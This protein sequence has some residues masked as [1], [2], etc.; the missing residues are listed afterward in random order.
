METRSLDSGHA[1]ICKTCQVIWLDKAAL[2]S[3]TVAVP[4]AHLSDIS[5]PKCSNC[6]AAIGSPLDEKCRYCGAA[7]EAAPAV[8]V[9]P[10]PVGGSTD[11]EGA[12][13][14][15]Y[16]FMRAVGALMESPW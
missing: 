9:A 7:L 6:G 10:A 4:V 13:H 15:A 1:A 2:G 16:W 11:W 3:L 8:I 12:G 5:V 14:A